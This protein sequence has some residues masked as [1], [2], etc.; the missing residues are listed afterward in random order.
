MWLS[1]ASQS[2]QLSPD[3]LRWP[4]PALGSHPGTGLDMGSFRVSGKDSERAQRG[5]TLASPWHPGDK[6]APVPPAQRC[7]HIRCCVLQLGYKQ[8]VVAQT[9]GEGHRGVINHRP[10][11]AHTDQRVIL[12][13]R[14]RKAHTEVWSWDD[15]VMRCQA[16]AGIQIQL[17]WRLVGKPCP[18]FLGSPG[19][20][21]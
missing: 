14:F 10:S 13:G 6:G 4:D 15:T 8:E 3:N 9:A 11:I 16:S 20:R 12:A 7:K 17:S 18:N 21:R 1:Q 2:S 19:M 5:L